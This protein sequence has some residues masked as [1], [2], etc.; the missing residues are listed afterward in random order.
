M[1]KKGHNCVNAD[2]YQEGHV[3]H[4]DLVS[5]CCQKPLKVGVNSVAHWF[6]CTGCD[7][8]TEP[9]VATKIEKPRT[10]R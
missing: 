2:D 9:F 6:I 5:M 7:N 3:L 8:V 4:E 10:K 1:S